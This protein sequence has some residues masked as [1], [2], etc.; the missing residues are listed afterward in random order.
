MEGATVC[1][2]GIGGRHPH[3]GSAR[4]VLVCGVR[5]WGDCEKPETNMIVSMVQAGTQR[6]RAEGLAPGHTARK[7]Q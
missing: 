2:G 5:I 4:C 1:N 6:L 3:V 7:S